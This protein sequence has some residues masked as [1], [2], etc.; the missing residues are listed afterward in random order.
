M[1]YRIILMCLRLLPRKL[2]G[3]AFSIPSGLCSRGHKLDLGCRIHNICPTCE[4][5]DYDSSLKAKL[6]EE[7]D[8]EHLAYYEAPDVW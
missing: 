7:Q 5:L 8:A 1:F 6:Q 2:Q 4:Q 3:V